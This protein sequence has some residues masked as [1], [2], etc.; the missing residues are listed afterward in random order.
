MTTTETVHERYHR[1][2]LEYTLHPFDYQDPFVNGELERVTH[3]LES[4]A[5]MGFHGNTDVGSA[6]ARARKSKM[7]HSNPATVQLKQ[8]L[9]PSFEAWLS[10]VPTAAALEPLYDPTMTHLPNG[11]LLEGDIINWLCNIGDARGMRG[12]GALVSAV[13]SREALEMGGNEQ[14]EWLS[15]AS[16][17]AKPIFQSMVDIGSQGGIIPKV[18]LADADRNALN[19]AST[20]AARV[21]LTGN[22]SMR[23]MNVLGINGPS[24]N[25]HPW[26]FMTNAF[27]RAGSLPKGKF[28]VVE[29]VGI[30][31]YLQ[32]EDWKYQYNSVIATKKPMAGAVTFIRNISELVRPGGIL[33]LGN[34]LDT[35]PQLGF[36]LNTIQWPHI[37]PRPIGA[38]IDIMEQAG[39]E[40]H[41]DV[42]LPTDGVYAGY[43]WRKP[44]K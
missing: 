7:D 2:R 28:Q 16:G 41:V 1:P 21:N 44:L 10:L 8:L 14:Q 42:Y 36:T 43:V 15:V 22:V 24:A 34:M 38:M 6:I 19:L 27:N 37:Q 35:H 17:A 29:G 20:N 32:V 33:F 3:E 31:E 30:T 40:G 39:L 26:S 25:M 13:T 5:A 23:R 18:T 12:R 4:L 9:G 11:V